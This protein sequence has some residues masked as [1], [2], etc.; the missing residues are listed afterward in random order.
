M[1]WLAFDSKRRYVRNWSV[2]FAA[3]DTHQPSSVF[4]L[5]IRCH[6]CQ[7]ATQAPADLR[8]CHP[9]EGLPGSQLARID[10][11]NDVRTMIDH[12]GVEWPRPVIDRMT[13]VG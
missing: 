6:R 7:N 11:D 1:I 9:K 10:R 3:L 4:P 8:K 5:A 13:S 2:S 12:L